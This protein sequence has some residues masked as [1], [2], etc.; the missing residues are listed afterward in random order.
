M[1]TGSRGI[2]ANV[3]NAGTGSDVAT[4]DPVSQA[5]R[6]REAAEAN[7]AAVTQEQERADAITGAKDASNEAKKRSKAAFGEKVMSAT[8]KKAHATAALAHGDAVKAYKALA[9]EG[10]GN[11]LEAR[12]KAQGLAEQ[13]QGM[14]DKHKAM[15]E[16]TTRGLMGKST[17]NTGSRNVLANGN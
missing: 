1:R 9:G 3:V 7:E 17:F 5:K 16:G 15:A 14:C 6:D 11:D 4:D 12:T 8:G 10:S 2:V 13:H